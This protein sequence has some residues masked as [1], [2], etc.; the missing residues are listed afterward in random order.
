[1]SRAR[2]LAGLLLATCLP[3]GAGHAAEVPN[4]G[5]LDHRIRS[6]AYDPHQVYRITGY[7]GYAM[8]LTFDRTE[9]IEQVV[10]GDPQAWDVR[11]D[12]HVLSLKPK[13]PEPDTSMVVL[14]DR[15]EYAFDVRAKPPRKSASSQAEDRDQ[16]FLVR[17]SYPQQVAAR[18]AAE[19]AQLAATKA[20][21]ALEA[22]RLETERQV[23]A[24]M[25]APPINRQYLFAGAD[26]LA[27]V[28]AWDD[29][30]FTYLRFSAEQGV[31]AVYTL[32]QDGEEMIAPKHFERDV[33]V[34]QQVARRV[35][36]RR[37]TLVTCLFNE[38]PVRS[39]QQPDNGTSDA[40][41]SR[42]LRGAPAGQSG[43]VPRL[44]RTT[45]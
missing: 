12:G 44:L 27:P 15:R 36:L 43:A 35:V 4:P 45:Q 14:T 24:N 20:A 18:E 9:R 6:V 39:T 28:E 5:T 16:A 29:G 26:A 22:A 10:L 30:R 19:Q 42:I 13:A 17:F 3:F 21:Q 25:P 7:F 32:S 33:V 2:L 1:M 41:S 31:P 11:I 40:A 23:V 37:G 38:G 34:I 8:T